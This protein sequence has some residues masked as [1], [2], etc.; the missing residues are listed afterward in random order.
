MSDRM[1]HT[2]LSFIRCT[3][4]HIRIASPP[5]T[6]TPSVERFVEDFGL[7]VQLAVYNKY[8]TNRTSGAWV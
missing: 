4:R 6:H 3:Y 5:D 7:S 1:E 2:P 8:T